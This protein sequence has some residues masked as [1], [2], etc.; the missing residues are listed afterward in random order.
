MPGGATTLPVSEVFTNTIQGEGPRAGM[1][2]QFVRLGGCNL[3]CSW[4]DS[5]YTWDASRYSLRAELTPMT[6]T[7]IAAQLTPGLPVVLSGGE[8]L[9]HQNSPAFRQ[10][11]HQL[12]M[13][14]CDVHV[15]TNG[16]LAP[17]ALLLSRETTFI[18]S[19]KL[20][21]AGDHKSSQ[22]PQP[23]MGWPRIARAHLKFVVADADDVGEAVARADAMGMPRRRTW[24]MPLGTTTEELLERWPGIARAAADHY[25]NASQRLHVLAWGDRKGT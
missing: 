12:T 7:E 6:A 15:E 4:C 10:L 21:N 8:P 25:I 5:A 13:M 20:G 16:T 17:P 19:P 2:C 14:N 3:S 24:V 1:A 11:I 22:S 9:L 23:W 18:V